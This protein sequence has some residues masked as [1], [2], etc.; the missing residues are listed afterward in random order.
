[1]TEE[2]IATNSPAL[3]LGPSCGSVGPSDG[4]LK[5]IFINVRGVEPLSAECAVNCDVDKYQIL[6]CKQ[7]FF[8]TKKA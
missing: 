3:L 2:N 7:L 5:A 6:Y 4:V 1:V 8:L